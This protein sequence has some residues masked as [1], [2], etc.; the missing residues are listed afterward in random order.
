MDWRERTYYWVRLNKSGAAWFE[1]G[2]DDYG[3][4]YE[5]RVKELKKI[6]GLK[7]LPLPMRKNGRV[8]EWAQMLV[9]CRKAHEGTLENCL[10]GFAAEDY[11]NCMWGRIVEPVKA[12][13]TREKRGTKASEKI[14]AGDLVRVLDGSCIKGYCGGW[15]ARMKEYVGRTL[16]VERVINDPFTEGGAKLYWGGGYTWDT[17]GLELVAKGK[18]QREPETRV[19]EAKEERSVNKIIIDGKEYELSDDLAEKI[20]A[21]VALQEIARQVSENPFERKRADYY[22]IESTGN[23]CVIF[24]IGNS[25]SDDGRFRSGNYCRDLG[26][27]EQRAL[28]ETLNRL[29]W[30]YSEGRG[31]GE[32]RGGYFIYRSNMED[33]RVG[34]CTYATCGDVYFRKKEVA[35]AAIEEVVKPFLAAHPEFEW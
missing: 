28:H 14:E 2:H 13:L 16:E 33:M 1:K 9:S 30:R 34:H 3:K 10:M 17:R 24:D 25:V 7:I 26:L 11:G 20:K 35:E 29:L 22:Y 6:P 27:M 15:T 32:K 19:E 5:R 18:V 21:E 23:V 31:G 12:W 8:P 4:E